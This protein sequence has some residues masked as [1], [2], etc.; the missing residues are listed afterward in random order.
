V[1]DADQPRDHDD[2]A[3][4]TEAAEAAEVVPGLPDLG[5]LGGGGLGGLLEPAQEMMAAQARAAEQ[6][7]EGVAGGGMVRVRVTGGGQVLGVHIDPQ[8][9][10][11]DDVT[12]LED[13]VTAAMRDANERLGALQREALGGLGDLLGGGGDDLGSLGG[14]LGEG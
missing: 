13:L 14:L 6:E 3:G 11:P 7:V 2:A 12:M 9:V 5:G 8:V 1:T 10:D 4:G